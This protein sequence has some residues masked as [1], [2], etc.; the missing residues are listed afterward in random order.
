MLQGSDT[1]LQ[2]TSAIPEMLAL[3]LLL[4]LLAFSISDSAY[5]SRRTGL[6]SACLFA[7]ILSCA[8]RLAL[9][10]YSAAP[11]HD[12]STMHLLALFSQLFTPLTAT[13][14][15][16]YSLGRIYAGTFNQRGYIAAQGCT[17]G[18]FA[19]YAVLCLSNH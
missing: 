11:L 17:W 9:I 3:I 5:A 15:F 6:F 2:A 7:G 8:F 18:I 1:M 10:F 4:I 14:L 16:S 19:V 12:H 13:L